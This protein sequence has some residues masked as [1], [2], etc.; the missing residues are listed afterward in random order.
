MILEQL[1]DGKDHRIGELAD[2]LESSPRLV[3]YELSEATAF[4]EQEGFPLPENDRMRG[5]SLTLS[6]RERQELLEKL[7]KLDSYEYAMDQDE[8]CTAIQLLLL[9]AGRYLTGQYL[10]EE[11]GVSKSSINKDLAL[12]RARLEG[13]GIVLDGK[14]GKGVSLSGDEDALRRHCLQL[15]QKNLDFT[16]FLEEGGQRPAIVER[17]ARALF[18]QPYLPDLLE[19]IHV[20]ERD[21]IGKWFTY[22]SLRLVGLSLAVAM[23][24]AEAGRRLEPRGDTAPVQITREYLFAVA[25]R[26]RLK[27]QF[28]VELDGPEC[29]NIAILLA[30]AKYM[31]PEPYLKED[32]A[33]IQVLLDRLVHLMEEKLGLAFTEDEELYNALQ[34]HLGPAVFRIRHHIP[35]ANPNLGEVERNYPEY[36]EA[37]DVSLNELGSALLSGIQRDDVGYLALHFCASAER[38][39]RTLPVSRVAIVCVH[40]AG[41]AS[42]M[43]ELVC[44]RFKNLRVAAVATYTDLQSLEK[45][46]V[47]FV[48]SSTSIPGCRIPWV[49]VNAIPSREDYAEIGRM[50]YEHSARKRP[51]SRAAAFFEDV[52]QVTRRCCEVSDLE[53]YMAALADCFTANGMQV[54]L[55]RVQPSLAQL[56][57]PEHIRLGVRAE[58]W[59]AAV[60][61]ACAVLEEGGCVTDEFTRSAVESVREAGPYIVICKGVAL[62]HG[63]M[64][65]GVHRLSMSL[66]T[67]AHPVCFHHPQ[68]DPVR[69]VLCLAPVDNWSHIEAL[70]GVLALLDRYDIEM[71]CGEKEPVSLYRYLKESSDSNGT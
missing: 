29:D 36:L 23:T 26:D 49:R 61:A 31:E 70:R 11:L 40:G 2:A 58:N 30:G 13:S 17:Y 45:L 16:A 63:Q 52:L 47:D 24:R 54:R 18:C 32:W 56:L 60:R 35:I 34:A 44:S 69:L 50:I 7:A 71:L 59:E 41:T 64:A 57:G 27:E 22:D 6:E 28:G 66:V 67:L 1:L 33:A 42:L 38:I 3:R 51:E 65:C 5:V 39:K 8:R 9:A 37:V 14:S 19:S 53:G 4:L 10:A 15:V 46:G 20:L 21:S 55:D 68:N 12:L 43:R 48:I 62:V 25:L